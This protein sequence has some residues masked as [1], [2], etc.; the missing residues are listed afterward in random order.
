MPMEKKPTDEIFINGIKY[1]V[2][3]NDDG[4]KKLLRYNEKFRI[5]VELGFTTESFPN[6]IKE[7]LSKQFIDRAA[8]QLPEPKTKLSC[9]V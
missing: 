7:V 9:A 8:N 2:T 5:W 4:S 1:I 6:T 3:Q